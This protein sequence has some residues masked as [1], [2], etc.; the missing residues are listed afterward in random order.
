MRNFIVIL[1][2]FV[3]IHSLAAQWS[4][5]EIIQAKER[6]L[7]LLTT[8]RSTLAQG[9]FEMQLSG[10]RT[11]S[12]F[13]MN[14]EASV[15][16]RENDRTY[17]WI[18]KKEEIPAGFSILFSVNVYVKDETEPTSTISGTFKKT[19]QTLELNLSA[20]SAA[21]GYTTDSLLPVVTNM[22]Q[23]VSNKSE[24]WQG[25]MSFDP[26]A[27]ERETYYSTRNEA[28][29]HVSSHV[30]PKYCFVWA[31]GPS[32]TP[33]R[34]IPGT[35]CAHWV[36]H[37]KGIQSSPG[38]YDRYGIRVSQVVSGKTR[39][40]ISDGRVGDIWTTTD[41]GHCGIVIGVN[42]GSVTVRHCSSGSGGVVVSTFT[43]GYCYR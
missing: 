1:L 20:E 24:W 23:C 43:S 33:W 3:L 8:S 4:G 5:K 34:P 25:M 14:Q 10:E 15:C 36:A 37:Q 19:Q 38:C 2:L 17:L 30:E 6:H 11:F 16:T 27:L 21:A 31:D 40:S 42:S 39:Y 35:G 7:S 22:S 41:L 9:T 13:T 32:S 12:I 26:V 28:V 29:A 18:A